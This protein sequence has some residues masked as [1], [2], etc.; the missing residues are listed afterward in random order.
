MI[1]KLDKQRKIFVTLFVVTL[2]ICLFSLFDADTL[3]LFK[4]TKEVAGLMKNVELGTNIVNVEYQIDGKLYKNR[5]KYDTFEKWKAIN[6]LYDTKNPEMVIATERKEDIK[7]NIGIAFVMS[8]LICCA[9]YAPA[10]KRIYK[11]KNAKVVE[12]E[13]FDIKNTEI[14]TVYLKVKDSDKIYYLYSD[15]EL[16][17]IL[18]KLNIKTLPIYMIS[19]IYRIDTREL[20]E[21]IKV[22]KE[23]ILF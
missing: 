5:I 14:C 21:K 20:E 11:N 17:P 1:N 2:I 8:I 6:L 9:Y 10:G 4:D 7:M 23:R 3:M 22:I 12:G 16:K 15:L 18:E 13:I 19:D